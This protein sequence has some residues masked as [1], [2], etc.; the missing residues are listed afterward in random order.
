LYGVYQNLQEIC[1]E[2]GLLTFGF[3]NFDR[4]PM[5]RDRDHWGVNRLQAE[6]RDG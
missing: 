2:I 5:R 6:V 1:A 4:E 3:A